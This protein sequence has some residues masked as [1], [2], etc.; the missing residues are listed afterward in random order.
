MG[1]N[2]YG[3]RPLNNVEPDY[4]NV[5]ASQTIA[6]GDWIILNANGDINIALANSAALYG[7]AMHAVV[8][9]AADEQ[10]EIKFW[11]A[12][13]G[14]QFIGYCSGTPTKAMRGVLCD[15]EGATGAMMV[16]ENAGT[17]DVLQFVRDYSEEA[18]MAARSP[19]IV[20]VA[21]SQYDGTEV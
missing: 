15:I 3:F 14:A 11:P 7:V 2:D 16:D 12:R 8:T 20:E 5:A 19:V 6:R 9:T 4:G 1:A 13:K 21:K 18:A 17:T 10:T